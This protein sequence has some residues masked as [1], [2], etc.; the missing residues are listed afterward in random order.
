MLF[1]VLKIE[2]QG[3]CLF[4]VCFKLSLSCPS[5]CSGNLRENKPNQEDLSSVRSEAR[6]VW[7]LLQLPQAGPCPAVQHRELEAVLPVGPCA[8]PTLVGCL[9]ELGS[10][11]HPV[12]WRWSLSWVSQVSQRSDSAQ[13][14]TAA[15]LLWLTEPCLH[16]GLDLLLQ[17]PWAESP[18]AHLSRCLWLGGSTSLHHT[19]HVPIPRSP[20]R[21]LSVHREGFA[22]GLPPAC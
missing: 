9:W 15:P 7:P 8:D 14:S 19:L 16:P 13:N 20:C 10:L 11:P 17:E 4:P 3:T 21:P 6:R 2:I 22:A 12:S 18:C 1:A 5:L